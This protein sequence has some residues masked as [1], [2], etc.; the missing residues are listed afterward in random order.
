M[1]RIENGYILE[2]NKWRILEVSRKKINNV[3]ENIMTM[4]LGQVNAVMSSIR[5][6]YLAS[7]LAGK[8][9]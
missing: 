1:P 8:E 5:K 2:N 3:L 7:V 6:I 9:G 4:D